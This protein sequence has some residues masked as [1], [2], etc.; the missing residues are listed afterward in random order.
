[1]FF[2]TLT[3][4][5]IM[6]DEIDNLEPFLSQF[7][8]ANNIVL[9]DTGS[10]DGT[11]E[12]AKE[13]AETDKRIR[14]ERAIIDPFNFSTA[15]NMA[16]NIAQSVAGEKTILIWADLDERFEDDWY[17]KLVTWFEDEYPSFDN[18]WVLFTNMDFNVA[19][20]GQVLMTYNQRKIHSSHGHKWAYACHEILV[21]DSEDVCELFQSN[22]HVRHEN[23]PSKAR[24][25]FDL[26]E[27]EYRERPHDLRCLYY[28]GRE[29]YYRDRFEE[30]VDILGQASTCTEMVTTAQLI[31][32]YVL[33]GD[34]AAMMNNHSVAEHFYLC[35]LS[36]DPECCLAMYYL[37]RD[38][39]NRGDVAG[40]IYWSN[41]AIPLLSKA[42]I[43]VIYNRTAEIAWQLYDYV[44]LG[45]DACKQHQDALQVYAVM[46]QQWQ[47]HVP[48]SDLQ[49]IQGNV[50][51]LVGKV[52]EA[53][54]KSA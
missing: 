23:D 16:M 36:I 49:R 29:L 11:W 53:G 46:M 34:A 26:L 35:A 21:P 45:Y 42:H 4:Y 17:T 9:L 33:G 41:R 25:Y 10:E 48:K 51:F 52:Q 8:Q 32:T 37:A 6:K 13:L 15:R 12:R 28:Y 44:A 14:L 27:N 2:P 38:C 24:D 30:A 7:S 20:N 5:A 22:I 43:N 40:Q 19:D 54:P 3:V 39:Y 1:M 31:E 18:P 50:Q 47:K